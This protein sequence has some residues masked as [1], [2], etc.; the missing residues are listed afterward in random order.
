MT[1]TRDRDVPLLWRP[2][3]P[4]QQQMAEECKRQ[5]KELE[6]AIRQVALESNGTKQTCQ[7][8]WK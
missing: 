4:S 5:F 3:M 8:Y 1:L 2:I 6:P 7:N